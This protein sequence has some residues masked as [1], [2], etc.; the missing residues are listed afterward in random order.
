MKIENM[1]ENNEKSSIQLQSKPELNTTS[2]KIHL[3]TIYIKERDQLE[4]NMR[5]KFVNHTRLSVFKNETRE[6]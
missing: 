6:G 1:N 2:K 3:F 4:R 5:D